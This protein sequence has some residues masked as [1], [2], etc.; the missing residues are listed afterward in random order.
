MFLTFAHL[1]GAAHLEEPTQK[2]YILSG[3]V[4]YGIEPPPQALTDISAKVFS[5]C[6]KILFFFMKFHAFIPH[7][8]NVSFFGRLFL[9]INI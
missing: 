4:R 3:H 7:F 1:Q 5:S 8:K 6:I 9:Q 2:T